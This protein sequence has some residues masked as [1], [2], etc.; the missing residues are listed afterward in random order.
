M[1]H[2]SGL[3]SGELPREAEEVDHGA[4]KEGVLFTGTTSSCSEPEMPGG[5]GDVVGG[6]KCLLRMYLRQWKVPVCSGHVPF[7]RTLEVGS[8]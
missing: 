1:S 8:R 3:A 4:Q 6:S 5:F 7:S 2:V